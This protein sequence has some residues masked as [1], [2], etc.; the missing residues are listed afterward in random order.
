[1]TTPKKISIEKHTGWWTLDCFENREVRGVI[2]ELE[3]YLEKYGE[4]C[5]FKSTTPMYSDI[6]DSS[7]YQHYNL[8]I[9]YEV[10]ET[11]LAYEKRIVREKVSRAKAKVKKAK[12]AEKAEEYRR[13]Q[14]AQLKKEFDD[15]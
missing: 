10:E 12:E 13:K 5:R 14:Y 9:V 7:Y 1:M 11:E 8:H 3:T 2:A 15:V 6:S 4:E